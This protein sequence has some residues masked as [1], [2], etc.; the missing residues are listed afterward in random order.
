M[1][2]EPSKSF[3]EVGRNEFDEWCWRRGLQLR[4]IVDGLKLAAETIR[5]ETGRELRA[6]SIETVRLICLPFTDGRRRVPGEGVVE[7]IHHFTDGAIIA[8]HFYP[9]SLRGSA[10][11]PEVAG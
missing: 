2:I 3:S 9:E 7:L 11:T 5:S 6:P 10:L 8:A 1:A 4:D